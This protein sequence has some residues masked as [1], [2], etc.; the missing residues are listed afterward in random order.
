MLRVAIAG[1]TGY[2]GEELIAI[3]LR[4]PQVRITALGSSGTKQEGPVPLARLYP[5]FAGR[6]DLACDKLDV[7][8][9]V[10]A[11]DAAFLALPHGMAMEWTPRLL[12]A[13]KLVIDLS[14]DFRLRDASLYPRWYQREHTQTNLLAQ[15]VYGLPELHRDQIRTAALIANPGCYPT[16]VILACWPLVKAGWVE[17]QRIIVDA[18]SGI[19]GAG[20]QPS[21]PLL[22][23]EA[24]E[25]LRAYKVHAHQH[26]PEMAQE[27][28]A[29]GQ[30]VS[31]TFVPHVVPLN[32][33]ILS[34]IYIRL[35][36]DKTPEQVAAL[37]LDA[38]GR[39]PFVRLRAHGELPQITD[40]ARTDYCDIGFALDASSRM[41]VV[42]SA[43][44]NLTKGA[45]GQAVQNLNIRQGW[46]ET[47]GLLN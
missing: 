37:F 31:L 12:K 1:A 27:L 35:A 21:T 20:R 40:V 41:L 38:Y 13:G 32:R 45:A 2:S 5:R 28:S 4:H 18:K 42:V 6:L 7:D 14:G 26:V 33:G 24:N 25:N 29:N 30:A 39:E 10:Q 43:I 17:G 44:D 23:G 19:T 8:Q 22:F 34:T 11:C 36:A 3:L 9:L 16:S 46:D 47:L 15:A